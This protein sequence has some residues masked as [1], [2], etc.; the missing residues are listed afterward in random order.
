[1]AIC[2]LVTGL[3]AIIV[4]LVWVISEPLLLLLGRSYAGLEQELRIVFLGGA[5][6][7]LADVMSALNQ[8]RGWLRFA[9]IQ[10]PFALFIIFFAVTQFDL[11]SPL[12][13]AI[14][15]AAMALPSLLAQI[16]QLVVGMIDTLGTKSA[17]ESA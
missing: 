5:V 12:Q 15:V 10:I 4:G 13:A 6:T 9:W 11:Q 2:A 7:C 8:A 17:S 16:V 14:V 1:M 3:L